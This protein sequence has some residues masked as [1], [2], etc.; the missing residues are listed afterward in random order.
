M[1][2]RSDG[3]WIVAGAAR[4][5]IDMVLSSAFGVG[6]ESTVLL[7][8]LSSTERLRLRRVSSKRSLPQDTGPVGHIENVFVNA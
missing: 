6:T 8:V 4:Q 2:A 7:N 1:Y 3:V 5:Q